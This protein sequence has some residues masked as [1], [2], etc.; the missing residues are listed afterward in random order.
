VDVEFHQSFITHFQQEGLACLL[1][2]DIGTLHNLEK[3]E[4]LLP[5]RI[6]NFLSIIQHDELSRP[7]L[8]AEADSSLAAMTQ[9]NSEP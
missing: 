6:Q 7:F 8:T 3:L 1:I 5:K 4:G 2:W 9:A